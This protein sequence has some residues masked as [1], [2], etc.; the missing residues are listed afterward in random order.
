VTQSFSVLVF[1]CNW[2]RGE[3]GKLLG[4]KI[5]R[6]NACRF[7]SDRAY[8]QKENKMLE[9]IELIYTL[10]FVIGLLLYAQYG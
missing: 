5:P 9:H 8:Q 10:A 6:R 1:G 3:I 2:A 4:L 7:E